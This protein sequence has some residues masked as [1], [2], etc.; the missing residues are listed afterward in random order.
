[1]KR[2]AL[3]LRNEFKLFKT[4]IPVHLIGIFQPALMFSLI[5]LVLV[6][7]DEALAARCDRHIRLEAGRI[8]NG[9][10]AA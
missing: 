5:A 3:L 1:M 7:H 2:F 6:T 4:A 9:Q 10:D 8:V